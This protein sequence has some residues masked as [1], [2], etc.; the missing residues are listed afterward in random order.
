PLLS[1]CLQK[2]TVG[3]KF[4]TRFRERESYCS[5]I[6]GQPRVCLPLKHLAWYLKCSFFFFF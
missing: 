5:R 3:T 6:Q 1:L 2:I 4:W